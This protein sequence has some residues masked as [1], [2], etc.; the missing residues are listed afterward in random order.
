L[1]REKRARLTVVYAVDL[2]LST[3]AAVAYDPRT[4]ASTVRPE[5]RRFVRQTL[6][7]QRVRRL[8]LVVAV[9]K[10]AQTLLHVAEHVGADVVVVGTHGLTG[11]KKV[12]FGSTTEAILRRSDVPV[13]AVPRAHRPLH[14]W[15]KSMLVLTLPPAGSVGRFL[16][17]ASAY[18][19]VHEARCPVLVQR[20]P[21]RRH[22]RRGRPRPSLLRSVA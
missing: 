5:L 6:R 16:E 7:L 20:L 8:R 14:T 15:R 3:A 22:V 10:P 11:L 4:I 21:K 2:L 9:G 19:L 1:A 17:A 18:Q 13:L 12:F